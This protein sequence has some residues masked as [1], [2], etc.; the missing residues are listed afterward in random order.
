VK[1][2]LLLMSVVAVLVALYACNNT[3]KNSET[4]IV[5]SIVP[6]IEL[7]GDSTKTIFFGRSG[8]F[9][10]KSTEWAL[11]GMGQLKKR[12]GIGE[13]WSL[14]Q[15]VQKSELDNL[16]IELSRLD[17]IPT[18]KRPGNMTFHL[19]VIQA[20]SSKKYMWGSHD[21]EADSTLIDLYKKL[22]NLTLSADSLSNEIED[23]KIDH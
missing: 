11:S 15:T 5:Q 14:V 8:G 17:T 22:M 16:F 18:C 13:E 9:T 2:S 3:R 23:E 1:L 7:K 10:G 6:G 12:T 4:P 19:D 20:D 21:F